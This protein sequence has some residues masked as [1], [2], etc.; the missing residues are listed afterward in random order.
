VNV[1]STMW[2]DAP[3]GFSGPG[4]L[5]MS[6]HTCP[7]VVAGGAVV[8][9]APL[10]APIQ[11]TGLPMAARLRPIDERGVAQESFFEKA[12]AVTGLVPQSTTTDNSTTLG[13]HPPGRPQS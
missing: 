11:G 1:I 8:R 4:S 12:I 6:P 7:S 13:I 2:T 10:A 9:M 5:G 3:A